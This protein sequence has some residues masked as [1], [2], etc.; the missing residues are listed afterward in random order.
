MANK[1]RELKIMAI[2]SRLYVIKKI[3][4]DHLFDCEL[5]VTGLCLIKRRGKNLSDRTNW[6]GQNEQDD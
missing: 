4:N 1:S 2:S 6:I 3:A 5:E